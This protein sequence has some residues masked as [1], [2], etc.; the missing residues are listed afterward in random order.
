MKI[1]AFILYL[2]LLIYYYMFIFYKGNL[3]THSEKIKKT[4]LI[5]RKFLTVNIA[6]RFIANVHIHASARVMVGKHMCTKRE[7]ELL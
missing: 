4:Q 2:F 6:L 5:R 1:N 7:R 3:I